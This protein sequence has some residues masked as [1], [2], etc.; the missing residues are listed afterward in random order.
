METIAAV[1]T[2]KTSSAISAI[3][4]DG[5]AASE[6][7]RSLTNKED[8]RI[9]RGCYKLY[10]IYDENGLIDETL[11]AREQNQRYVINCHG[12]PIIVEKIM[13]AASGFGAKTLPLDEYAARDLAQRFPSDII[14]AEAKLAFI[15]PLS[16]EA[17]ELMSNQTKNGLRAFAQ[18]WLA[19]EEIDVAA[20]HIEC[21]KILSDS[22]K[23]RYLFEKQR[24]VLAGLPN[25]GK[26]TLFNCFSGK[27]A[28]IVTDVKGTTRDW[29]SCDCSIGPMSVEL[30]DT[31][32]IDSM[33]CGNDIDRRSQKKTIELVDKADVILLI[34]DI[35]QPQKGSNNM[36]EQMIIDSDSEAIFLKVYNKVDL[37]KPEFVKKF[38]GDIVISA[39][40]ASGVDVVANSIIEAC[41]VGELTSDKIVCFTARQRR[42]LEQAAQSDSTVFIKQRLEKI[43]NDCL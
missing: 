35:S 30:I 20:F 43:I 23:A 24:V 16:C 37:C 36:I 4:V 6:I 7:C 40:K 18:R 34:M 25:S 38:E 8:F 27:D 15:Q 26:S 32:G 21:A 10:S 42:L 2:G 22:D 39:A 33:L 14:S 41:G 17:F 12:N 11:I 9:N 3:A 28:A 5:P 31:A 29:I 19:S 1:I 13:T